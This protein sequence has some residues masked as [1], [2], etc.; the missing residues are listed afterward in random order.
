MPKKAVKLPNG[1]V[2]AS[3]KDAEAHF[4]EIRDKFP[5][6]NKI[7]PGPEFEDLLA[8]LTLYD[9]NWPAEESKIGSGVSYF[10]TRINRTNGGRTIGFWVVRS[11]GTSLDF[12]FI[13]AI[14]WASRQS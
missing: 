3:Q 13:K 7:G 1:A 9:I 6:R 5:P 10:E 4:R 11:D 14:A 2:W 12:S 8:L